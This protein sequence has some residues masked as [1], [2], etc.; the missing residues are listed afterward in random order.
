[1]HPLDKIL[2]QYMTT[3]YVLGTY[4]CFTVVFRDIWAALGGA[5]LDDV[6]EAIGDYSTNKPIGLARAIKFF[7]PKGGIPGYA[8][9]IG[10]K[11]STTAAEDTIFIDA[12]YKFFALCRYKQLYIFETGG[13]IRHSKIQDNKGIYIKL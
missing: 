10:V 4:D 5:P 2:L 3:P 12:D 6:F 7:G 8:K 9:S 13:K 11:T 1:M